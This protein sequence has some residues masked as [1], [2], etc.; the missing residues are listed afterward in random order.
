MLSWGDLAQLWAKAMNTQVKFREVGV[1]EFKKRFPV[2]GEELLSATCCA[3]FGFT[4]R[5]SEVL[6]PKDLGFEDRPDDV[7]KWLAEQDWSAVFE[8]EAEDI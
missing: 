8:A 3:E 7:E 1:D 2:D 5:D 6:E 4:G